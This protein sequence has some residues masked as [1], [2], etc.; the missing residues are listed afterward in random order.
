MLLRSYLFNCEH[1]AAYRFKT[2]LAERNIQ[3]LLSK[4]GVIGYMS[5]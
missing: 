5:H 1:M 2:S 4:L 3:G